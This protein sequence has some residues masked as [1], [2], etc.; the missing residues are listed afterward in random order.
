LY[1]TGDRGI[2]AADGTIDYLGRRDRQVKVRG[3]RVELGDVEAQLLRVPGVTA[4]ACVFDAGRL[5]AYVTVRPGP[6][7]ASSDH[8][9]ERMCSWAPS[10]LIPHEVSVLERLPTGPSGKVD[11]QALIGRG[12]AASVDA[13]AVDPDAD[14]LLELVRKTVAEVLE[15]PAVGP[16]DDFFAAGGD[17]LRAM[18]LV[19][20]A[21]KRFDAEGASLR[22]FLADPTPR[23]LLTVL[24]DARAAPPPPPQ[25]HLASGALSSGQE[26]LWFV[27]QLHPRKTPALIHLALTLRGALAPE[28]LQHALD[29]LV[30]RHEPLRTVFTQNRGVPVATVWPHA[31]LIL[32]QVPADEVA[33]AVAADPGNPTAA[34]VDKLVA[35]EAGLSARTESPPLMTA[36]LARIAPDHH[37]L[38]LVLHHLVADGWSLAVLA[39][40]IGSYYQRRVDGDRAVPVPATTYSQ[41][42]SA[43]RQWLDSPE[44]AE[45]ERYWREQLDGAP[46]T[47]EL[48]L[49]RPRPARPSFVTE[50][51]V[52][53]LTAQE[54]AALVATARSVRG[55]PFMAVMAAFYAVLRDLAGTG[56]LVLGIDSVNRT[57]PGSE[58]LIG[59]FVNQLPVRLALAGPAASFRTLLELARRQCV[60]AYEHDRLP[61]HKIVAAVNPPRRPGRFPLFQVKLTHQSAWRTGVTLPDIEVVPSE[62]SDPVM[63]QE[64]MLDVS[65]ESDRLRLELLYWPDVLDRSTADTWV[66]AVVDVL[67]T[68]AADPDAVVRLTR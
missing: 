7:A 27:E 46:P 35:E 26:R 65:G 56:D 62:I 53:R 11:H 2:R 41:Y 13:A 16:D 14:S 48:P 25:Q 55:T 18:T 3:H 58:D 23:R 61:F 47:L 44:G 22:G 6:D 9:L 49:D 19:S 32:Q 31:E 37:V 60:G 33:A 59:T 42:V 1:R 29:A 67:R 10:Y 20:L 52:R 45:C 54:T 38:L 50:H 51:V 57:W 66:D 12:P 64:L 68:G 63:D 40:D 36:R 24:E 21:R 17:S 43:E 28:A 8:I 4:A 30:A 5:Q 15:V 39:Q 34:L